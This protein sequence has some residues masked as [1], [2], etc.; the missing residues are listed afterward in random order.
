MSTEPT[1]PLPTI[2]ARPSFFES[3]GSALDIETLEYAAQLCR[4]CD[5]PAL[6][7]AWKIE[8][9]IKRLS[10]NDQPSDPLT[11][12]APWTPPFLYNRGGQW[13]EDIRGHQ[14]LDMRGWGF[15][16]GC[17]GGLG[18]DENEA[19]KI[20]DTIGEHVAVLMNRDATDHNHQSHA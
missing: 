12:Y 14:I 13:I 3:P 11:G 4:R 2:Q 9:I 10:Q 1:A 5:G 6:Q 17:G 15:L 16:T 7:S 19:A 8:A 18:M 20:Q